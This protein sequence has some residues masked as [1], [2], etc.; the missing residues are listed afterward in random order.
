MPCSIFLPIHPKKKSWRKEDDWRCWIPSPVRRYGGW[1]AALCSGYTVQDGTALAAAAAA[2]TSEKVGSGRLLGG[3]ARASACLRSS[4]NPMVTW[5][6]RSSSASCTAGAGGS[7]VARSSGFL[8]C[9]LGGSSPSLGVRGGFFLLHSLGPV[10]LCAAC[11]I[12]LAAAAGGSGRRGGWRRG[13]SG[14][15]ESEEC[16]YAAY[17]NGGSGETYGKEL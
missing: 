15:R 6:S 3:G 14:G 8:R 2:L 9:A 12:P 10:L 16:R 7:G 13:F 11:F 17:W 5:R 1:L 4:T